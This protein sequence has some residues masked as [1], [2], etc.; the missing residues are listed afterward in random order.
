MV[1]VRVR[2][3]VRVMVRVM[4][5]VV[6]SS[7]FVEIFG[8]YTLVGLIVGLTYIY[9][10]ICPILFCAS[11]LFH[12]VCFRVE[13][14]IVINSFILYVFYFFWLWPITDVLVRVLFGFFPAQ[15]GTAKALPQVPVAGRW[16]TG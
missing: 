2:V 4:V 14:K 13:T 12:S 7:P 11:Y 16:L 15:S 8:V 9:I 1:M 10:Y 6:L 3:R 5:M